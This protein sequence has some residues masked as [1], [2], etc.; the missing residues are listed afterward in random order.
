MFTSLS[1]KLYNSMDI[2][3]PCDVAFF[4]NITI[5]LWKIAIIEIVDLKA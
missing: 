3:T 4:I 5:L 2:T 1:N